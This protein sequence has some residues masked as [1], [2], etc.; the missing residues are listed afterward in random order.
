MRKI[1]LS[2]FAVAL[3]STGPALA[4]EAAAPGVEGPVTLAQAPAPATELAPIDALVAP[5]FVSVLPP[6][7]PAGLDRPVVSRPARPATRGAVTAQR[8]APGA[9]QVASAAAPR[10]CTVMCGRFILIGV[11]F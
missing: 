11:G 5:P 4:F 7:R 10:R 2:L 6:R 8:A 1:S 3:L 9:M